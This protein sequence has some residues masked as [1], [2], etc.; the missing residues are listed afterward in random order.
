MLPLFSEQ[1]AAVGG[2]S[3]P[4]YFLHI[5][6]ECRSMLG[7]EWGGGEGY[8]DGWNCVRF[9]LWLDCSAVKDL[10]LKTNTGLGLPA[11]L[12]SR[13]KW[14]LCLYWVNI[15]LC[16]FWKCLWS[17]VLCDAGC[18]RLWIRLWMCVCDWC[19]LAVVILTRVSHLFNWPLS[20]KVWF[21]SLDFALQLHCAV[22]S[23]N[24]QKKLYLVSELCPD[25][26]HQAE[27]PPK[28]DFPQ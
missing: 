1:F 23:L 17:L 4:L 26:N 11:C 8:S 15:A 21:I 20:G 6:A 13:A 18:S 25:F 14:L 22:L 28:K 12:G 10:W 16:Y 24:A 7:W 2:S 5:S 27:V 19:Y 3:C 9:A